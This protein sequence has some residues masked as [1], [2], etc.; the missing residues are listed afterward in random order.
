M[1]K[2]FKKRLY[3]KRKS[4]SNSRYI[5]DEAI[6]NF[7]IE[8]LTPKKIDFS[9][10]KDCLLFK[11]LNDEKEIFLEEKNKENNGSHFL[12]SQNMME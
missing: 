3:V 2:I 8:H 5:K 10:I 9:K 11:M 4:K 7:L 6:K 12:Q 1:K